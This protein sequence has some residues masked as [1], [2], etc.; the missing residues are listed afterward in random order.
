MIITKMMMMMFIIIYYCYY[1]NLKYVMIGWFALNLPA[2]LSLYY[3]SNITLTTV[4]YAYLKKGGGASVNLPDL[5]PITKAGSGRKIGAP[6][7]EEE[8]NL[9]SEMQ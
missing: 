6:I 3:V 7:T 5:G 2:G 8:M 4:I 1:S 9:L